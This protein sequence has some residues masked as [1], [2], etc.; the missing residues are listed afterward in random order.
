MHNKIVLTKNPRYH[1]PKEVGLQKLIMR[2]ITDE[3]TAF[4]EYEAGKADII[5][6]VPVPIYRKLKGQNRDDLYVNPML[7]VY[8]IRFN[9]TRPPFDNKDVRRAIAWAIDPEFITEKITASGEKPA[10]SF[11]PSGTAGRSSFKA[12]KMF[13]PKQ[14]RALLQK[15]GYRIGKQ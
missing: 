8:Y 4:N 15:A 14:A 6:T 11:V 9:V 2:I 12:D 1:A 10:Y 5:T 3:I 7:G 13:N